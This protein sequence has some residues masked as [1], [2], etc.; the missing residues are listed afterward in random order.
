[1]LFSETK[2]QSEWG[3]WYWGTHDS[4]GLTYQSGPDRE[5]R[6]AFA[7]QGKLTNSHDNNYRAISRNWPIFG[8]AVDLGSVG[9]E[10][11]DRLFTINLAQEDAI[12]YSGATGVRAVPSLWTSYFSDALDAVC[13]YYTMI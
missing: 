3:S 13:L 5:V 11:V 8:F 12:Q 10:T 7:R 2:D 1:M 9:W 6:D 4:T